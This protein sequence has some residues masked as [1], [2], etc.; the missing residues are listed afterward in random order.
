MDGDT[1]SDSAPSDG[2][3]SVEDT[4]ASFDEE[5]AARVLCCLAGGSTGAGDA[6]VKRALAKPG[7]GRE[8]RNNVERV[9]LFQS[10]TRQALKPRSS[11]VRVATH[12]DVGRRVQVLWLPADFPRYKR[13]TRQ[14]LRPYRGRVVEHKPVRGRKTHRVLYHDKSI[15]WHSA[16]EITWL[17]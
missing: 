13:S 15:S 5:Q 1:E 14:D 4:P 6:P 7:V 17:S 9:R 10:S 8:A 16:A 12:N 3:A 2:E 11:F